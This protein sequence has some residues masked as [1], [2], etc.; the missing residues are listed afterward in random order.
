MRD[1]CSTWFNQIAHCVIYKNNNDDNDND[2]NDDD[3]DNNNNNYD[4]NDNNNNNCCTLHVFI[5]HC[6]FKYVYSAAIHHLE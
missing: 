1:G 2:N 3:G 4:N 6:Q 5:S